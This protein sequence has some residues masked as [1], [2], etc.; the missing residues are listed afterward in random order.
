MLQRSWKER[1]SRRQHHLKHLTVVRIFRC[2][3]TE[4][5]SE[6]SWCILFRVVTPSCCSW[7][8]PLIER[9]NS[10]FSV[11]CF[12]RAQFSCLNARGRYHTE[13]PSGI[14]NI[15][16][17]LAN[18]TQHVQNSS[19]MPGDGHSHI[20]DDTRHT[21]LGNWADVLL[22]TLPVALQKTRYTSRLQFNALI[23]YHQE[24]NRF[25]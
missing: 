18:I 8:P 13:K 2:L 15:H 24:H 12:F 6:T 4:V 21:W 5:Q 1:C 10:P 9:S 23:K 16:R 11:M 14:Q 17:G 22:K 20:S 3:K 25:D 19:R 7:A